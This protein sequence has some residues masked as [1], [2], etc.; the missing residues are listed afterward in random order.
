M[1]FTSNV[2]NTSAPSDFMHDFTKSGMIY[3][4]AETYEDLATQQEPSAGSLYQIGFCSEQ[5][6]EPINVAS[7]VFERQSC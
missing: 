7:W 6:A 1:S 4:E 2:D 3:E 5:R